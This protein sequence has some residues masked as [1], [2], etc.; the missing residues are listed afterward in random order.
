MVVK[1][2][3]VSDDVQE[4]AAFSPER[5]T[6]FSYLYLQKKSARRIFQEIAQELYNKRHVERSQQPVSVKISKRCNTDIKHV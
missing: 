4:S 2:E 1:K 6:F 3:E 5:D